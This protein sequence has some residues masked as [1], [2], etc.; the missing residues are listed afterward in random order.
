MS[1]KRG[2]RARY[3]AYAGQEVRE[4][5]EGRDY[6]VSLHKNTKNYYMM[7][8]TATGTKRKWLG[9]DISVAVLKFRSIVAELKGQIEKAILVDPI[10][11]KKPTVLV[12]P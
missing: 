9:S 2:R 6:G 5:I 8:S 7:L 10:F 1:K 3:V 11:F 12:Q 4:T